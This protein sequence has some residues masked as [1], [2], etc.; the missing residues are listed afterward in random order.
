MSRHSA[1]VHMLGPW[2]LGMIVCERS[3]HNIPLRVVFVCGNTTTKRDLPRKGSSGGSGR[4]GI[5]STPLRRSGSKLTTKTL[6]AGKSAPLGVL[7]WGV[8]GDGF[9][10][11]SEVLLPGF[12]GFRARYSR[13]TEKGAW[14]E[15]KMSA[16]C[17]SCTAALHTS[18]QPL[19]LSPESF[20]GRAQ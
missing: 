10:K 8:P 7:R 15:L 19:C 2:V 12:H 6:Q 14:S 17:R 13:L 11:V 16:A 18:R 5:Q 3:I 9:C 4:R 1:N 20:S